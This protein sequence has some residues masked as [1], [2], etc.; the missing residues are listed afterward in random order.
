MFSS[1][2]S[3]IND[4]ACIESFWLFNNFYDLINII[5]RCNFIGSFGALF[6][7]RVFQYVCVSKLLVYEGWFNW[8]DT[9]SSTAMKAAYTPEVGTRN[10]NIFFSL[11]SS[12]FFFF[13]IFYFCSFYN[14]DP[15]AGKPGQIPLDIEP[16]NILRGS[17]I[18]E[19]RNTVR[20]YMLKEKNEK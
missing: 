5:I 3:S 9:G 2:A 7:S 15:H 13:L 14:A 6:N 18:K 8:R 16:V 12:S 10:E 19:K 20:M 17:L 1:E 4:V 11:K